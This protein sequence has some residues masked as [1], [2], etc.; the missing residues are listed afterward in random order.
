MVTDG[1]ESGPYDGL[2]DPVFSP[3]SKHIAFPAR[4]GEREFVS[5]DGEEMRPFDNVRVPVYSPDSNYLAYQA[6]KEDKWFYVLDKKDCRERYDGFLA[7][8]PIIFDSNNRFHGLAY[9]L[10]GPEFFKVTVDIL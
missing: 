1:E 3:D 5:I 9:R 7:D 6:K 4:K 2:G 8:A 10:P